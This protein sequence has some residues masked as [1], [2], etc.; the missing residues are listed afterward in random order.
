MRPRLRQGHSLW[1]LALVG[2]QSSSALAQ[3]AATA[4]LPTNAGSPAFLLT[5]AVSV[6]ETVTNNIGGAGIAGPSDAITRATAGLRLVNR[7]GQS[8]AMVD[9]ALSGLVY[10]RNSERNTHQ[11]SLQSL[12]DLEWFEQRGLLQ[13]AA[14][15][16]Q[17]AV[18]A[19]GA[20]PT[21]S[22]LP[23]TNVVEVRTGRLSPRWD[24]PLGESLR[25]NALGQVLVTDAAGSSTG[26]STSY[27][28]SLQISPYRRG[29]LGWSLQLAQQGSRFSQGRS[30]NT[31]RV[32]G[33]LS[34]ELDELDLRLVANAGYER[35]SVVSGDSRSAANWGVG[36]TWAP[37]PRTLG[38]VSYDRRL[39]GNSYAVS[40]EHRTPHT[41]WRA[42]TSRRLN[43]SG[44]DGVGTNIGTAYDLFFAQLASVEPDP[45]RRADLVLAFLAQNGIDPGTSVSAGFL[46][47]ATT[48]DNLQQL[49]A[50]W[51]G[52][53][54]TATV[55]YTRN[56]SQ[57]ANALVLADD[58][59]SNS[60]VVVTTSWSLLLT[61]R[62]TP[63]LTAST[64]VTVQSGDGDAAAQ[65]SRQRSFTAQVGGALGAKSNWSVALRR[66]LYETSLVP[67]GETT[68]IAT[69]TV[70]F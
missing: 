40:L 22:A 41:V 16:S 2:L 43:E 45:V 53:R 47:S 66:A 56:R 32:L 18:S 27:S 37:S 39:F 55:T 1:L 9:Y 64:S 19:F 17:G 46:R 51:R 33:G 50:A 36:V 12:L 13:A 63:E 6:S 70:R 69:Y 20:Q 67:S 7:T 61:H 34:R 14:T 8:K 60:L 57:R 23:T 44:T 24:G 59:L 25:L 30:S 21:A 29:P 52:P 54:S 65:S 15:I 49:S 68:A 11:Q 31:V 58:D 10:A 42:L 38:E 62:L 3:G 5:P 4:G 35:G 28:G 26:D 48:I